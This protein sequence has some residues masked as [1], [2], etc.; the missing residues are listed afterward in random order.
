MFVFSEWN[1]Q[2]A[3]LSYKKCGEL[4]TYLGTA[5]S[6]GE[7][8]KSSKEVCAFY[9]FGDWREREFTRAKSNFKY[10]MCVKLKGFLKM[11]CL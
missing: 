1:G 8:E 4:F 9:I 11:K 3:S 10:A 7:D 2:D 5:S 6:A